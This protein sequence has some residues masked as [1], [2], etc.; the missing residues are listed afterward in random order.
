MTLRIKSRVLSIVLM[1]FS[2]FL[3]SSVSVGQSPPA[4]PTSQ[5]SVDTVTAQ[6]R[7]ARSR[8][9]N[10]DNQFQK[11]EDRS[12]FAPPLLHSHTPDTTL[13]ELPA[14]VSGTILLGTITASQVNQSEDH[15][16]LYTESTIKVERVINQQQLLAKEGNSIAVTQA[17]G[18]LLLASGRML[19]HISVGTGDPLQ[20]GG[21][22]VFFLLYASAG[23]CYKIATAWA[24][25]DGYARA[26]GAVDIERAQ[27]GKSLYEGMPETEFLRKV[28]TLTASFKP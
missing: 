9:Y 5:Q 12:P 24:L 25:K 13:D 16:T 15:R 11:L 3:L 8:M 17:G 28:S 26:M 14:S 19:S 21:R 22:Y 1:P 7:L 6:I 23:Q 20:I 4:T 18:N 10:V 2:L 27:H